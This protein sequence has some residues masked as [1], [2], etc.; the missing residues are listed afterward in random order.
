MFMFLFRTN[1]D[2]DECISNPCGGNS[3]CQD[4]T[5]GYQ[6]SC[7]PGFE[8]DTCNEGKSPV[9]SNWFILHESGLI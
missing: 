1:A 7:P 5:N 4:M 2:I 8:G 6:C 3:T 9:D